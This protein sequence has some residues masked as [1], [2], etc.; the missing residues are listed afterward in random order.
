MKKV[1]LLAVLLLALIVI[2]INFQQQQKSFGSQ[3]PKIKPY[4]WFLLERKSNLEHLYFGL[5]GDK[6]K[7]QLVK[8]FNVKAGIPGEKPTPLPQLL[9][10]KYW[11][12]IDKLD[13][14]DNPETAPYFLI[15]DVPVTNEPP[16]GPY[17]YEECEK[18]CDWELPGWFGLHGT[19]GQPEKLSEQDP[20]SFGCVRHSDEDIT[21]LYNLLEPKNNPVRYYIQDT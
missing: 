16:Y 19:A 7:S 17:P 3:T 15:L 12:I 18:Q 5:P 21:Y 2:D 6:N 20:G 14:R 1:L 4:Y 9:G 13:S 8:T 11:L 10:R